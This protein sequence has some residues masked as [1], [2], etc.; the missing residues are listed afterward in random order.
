MSTKKN[1]E[2][3]LRPRFSIDFEESQQEIL[4]NFQTTLKD[5]NCVYD[6]K[7]VAEHIFIDIPKKENHFWSP[8]LHLE[9]LTT[10]NNTSIVKGLFGPKPQVWTL[11]MFVHFIVAAAF[12]VFLILF[13]TKWRLHSSYVF[14]LVML[15]VLP[16][17]WGVLYF[18]GKVGKATGNKQMEELYVFM[19]K[20]LEKEV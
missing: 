20:T 10:E 7:I 19:L 18:L 15:I 5:S 6:S 3:F 1:N 16:I 12:I 17:F 14:P 11:F 13:Y 9:I 8:Q 4:Q 2:L